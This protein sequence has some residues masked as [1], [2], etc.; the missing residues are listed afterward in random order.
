MWD[1]HFF[2]GIIVTGWNKWSCEKKRN[3]TNA[4]AEITF[5]SSLMLIY[6]ILQNAIHCILVISES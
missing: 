1:S 2:I 4:G 6:L 5:Y 3:N